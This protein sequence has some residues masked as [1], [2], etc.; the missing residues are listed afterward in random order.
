MKKHLIFFLSFIS[1]TS[2]SQ[3]AIDSVLAITWVAEP[4]EYLKFDAQNTAK[5]YQELYSYRID[6]QLIHIENEADTISFRYRYF[7]DSIE[8]TA[9]SGVKH[10]RALPPKYWDKKNDMWQLLT[11][12]QEVRILYDSAYLYT[13]NIPFKQLQVSLVKGELTVDSSGAVYLSPRVGGYCYGLYKAESLD[14]YTFQR[15]KAHIQFAYPEVYDKVRDSYD[16]S[17]RVQVKIDKSTYYLYKRTLERH[18]KKLFHFLNAINTDDLEFITYNGI[19]SI[20]GL[21]FFDI[22]PSKYLHY[23]LKPKLLTTFFDTTEHYIYKA[24]AGTVK[25]HI[26]GGGV[27]DQPIYLCS[28]FPLDTNTRSII[29]GNKPHHWFLRGRAF[30]EPEGIILLEVMR[31]TKIPDGHMAISKTRYEAINFTPAPRV[32]PVVTQS[33]RQKHPEVKTYY[34]RFGLPYPFLRPDFQVA[35]EEYVLPDWKEYLKSQKSSKQ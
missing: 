9:L 6:E 25:T 31:E 15:L 32:R 22:T 20:I 27:I 28:H 24:A 3:S 7:G 23:E 26:N 18:G 8:L 19:D 11:P 17:V 34:T 35:F 30:E 13:G 5:L 12:V 16:G 14:D 21:F 10:L 29:E 2:F 33:N 4:F 1:F